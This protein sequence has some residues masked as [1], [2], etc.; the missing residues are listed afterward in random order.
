MHARTGKL[1]VPS[2]S[3]GAIEEVLYRFGY[4]VNLGLGLYGFWNKQEAPAIRSEILLLIMFCDSAWGRQKCLV[5]RNCDVAGANFG[6]KSK[7]SGTVEERPFQGR[8]TR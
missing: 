6:G 4:L 3:K 8:V 1:S 5:N 2:Q 7:V